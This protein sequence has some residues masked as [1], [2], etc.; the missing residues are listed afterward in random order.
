MRS[1]RSRFLI[2]TPFAWSQIGSLRPESAVSLSLN[3]AGST[4]LAVLALLGGQ[5]GFLL[6]ET[7]WAVVTGRGFV[8]LWA[9]RPDG[10]P[11]VSRASGWRGR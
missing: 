5:W 2:L 11:E 3:L 1:F 7:A 6:L 4:L 9:S 10:Q 8:R